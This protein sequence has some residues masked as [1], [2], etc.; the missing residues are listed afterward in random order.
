M[1]L[2]K[3]ANIVKDCSIGTEL[4]SNFRVQNLNE[5]QKAFFILLGALE[6]CSYRKELCQKILLTIKEH[7]KPSD[8]LHISPTFFRYKAR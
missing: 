5:D 7:H 8:I 3:T 4:R 1:P 6:K 2:F